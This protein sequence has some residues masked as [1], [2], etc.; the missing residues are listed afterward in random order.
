MASI[1]DESISSNQ[2]ILLDT[3]SLNAVS[4]QQYPTITKTTTA[5]A[6]IAGA[7]STPMTTQVNKKYVEAE[8]RLEE[9]MRC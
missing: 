6:T 1:D 3:G 4:K 8:E 2:R 7:P 5:A 9:K